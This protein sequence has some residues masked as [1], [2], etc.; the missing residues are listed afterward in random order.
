M[1]V[2]MKNGLR[3]HEYAH[4]QAIESYRVIPLS[5]DQ[6]EGHFDVGFISWIG[7]IFR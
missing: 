4:S 2:V 5:E 3:V 1:S 6:R 7:T